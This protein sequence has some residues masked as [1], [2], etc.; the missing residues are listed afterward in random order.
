MTI[1]K[2]I[3]VGKIEGMQGNITA[4]KSAIAIVVALV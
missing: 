2:S 3:K 4:M 1:S